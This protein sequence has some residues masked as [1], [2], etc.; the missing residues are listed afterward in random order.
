MT[1]M[2][3]PLKLD[4]VVHENAPTADEFRSMMHLLPEPTPGAFL[5]APDRFKYS[6]TN[7]NSLVELI[8]NEPTLLS[9]PV[10]LDWDHEHIS[11][12]GHDYVSFLTRARRRRNRA[13]S[14]S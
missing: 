10:I 14:E 11:I 13:L 4:L 2:A 6:P 9:W 12:G 1:P 7:V 5:R 3:R 8:K